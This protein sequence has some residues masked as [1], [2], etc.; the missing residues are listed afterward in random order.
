MHPLIAEV[1]KAQLKKIS[2]LKTGYTVRVHQRIREGEKERVQIFEGLVIAVG[3]GQ[4]VE[5]TFTV[6]KVVEGV[7]VEKVFPIHSPNIVKIEVR[8][9]A[10]VRRS[11]L[12]YMRRRSGKSARLTERHLTDE[13][14]AVEEAKMQALLDE[15]VKAE[16]ARK[17]AEAKTAAPAEETLVA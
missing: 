6:R 7:G 16:N 14:R 2:E 8:K 15:A 3:H 1:Q 17:K 9:E 13:E 10:T 4:G 12:Y 11:K 5:K